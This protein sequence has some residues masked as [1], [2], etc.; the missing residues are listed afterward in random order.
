M[1]VRAAVTPLCVRA[2]A[3]TEDGIGRVMSRYG[4]VGR[5]IGGMRAGSREEKVRINCPLF[6]FE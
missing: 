3:Q 4:S 5:G 6:V 2:R 1:D